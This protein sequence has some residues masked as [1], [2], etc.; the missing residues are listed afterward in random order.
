MRKIRDWMCAPPAFETVVK[1]QAYAAIPGSICFDRH[2]T[3]SRARSSQLEEHDDN[4]N[5]SE[6]ICNSLS[7]KM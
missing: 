4:A 7:I 3:N 6:A 5:R 1:I 2:D